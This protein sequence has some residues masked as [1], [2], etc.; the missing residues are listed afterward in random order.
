[1]HFGAVPSANMLHN[2][3]RQACG[4]EKPGSK[5]PMMFRIFSAHGADVWGLLAPKRLGLWFSNFG[6]PAAP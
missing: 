2:F 3:L 5:A 6:P 4:A 1:M